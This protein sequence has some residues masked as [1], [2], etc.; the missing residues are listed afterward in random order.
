MLDL[1]SIGPKYTWLNYKMG[2]ALIKE[3]IDKTYCNVLWRECFPEAFVRNLPRTK[4]DHHLIL[5]ALNPNQEIDKHLKPFHFEMAWMYHANF[6]Q[7]VSSEWK[8][9][10]TDISNSFSS[11]VDKLSY[12]NTKVFDNIL[13][14]ETI[15]TGQ[16]REDP[17]IMVMFLI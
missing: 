6:R 3:Q 1:G 17:M 11:F 2:H 14:Q 15:I 16:V 13:F 7:F 9:N 8:L 10:P 5:I 12:W 4:S